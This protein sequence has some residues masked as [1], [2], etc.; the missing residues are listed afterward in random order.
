M[1]R[2][3]IDFPKGREASASRGVSR[4]ADGASTNVDAVAPD[5]PARRRGGI[6]WLLLAVLAG[7][8]AALLFIILFAN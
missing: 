3:V 5:L 8:A 7:A 1:P 6:H 2:D 4:V